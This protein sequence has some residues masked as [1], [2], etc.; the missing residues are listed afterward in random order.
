MAS[1]SNEEN[2]SSKSD[3]MTALRDKVGTAVSIRTQRRKWSGRTDTWDRHNDAGMV[4]VAAK[5]IE[6]CEIRP[7]MD[8]VDLG[9]GTGRLTLQL[10][11]R[12]VNIIGVDVSAAMIER[13][14]A[15]AQ[16]QEA[17][18]GTVTGLAAPIERLSLGAGSVDLVITNYALHHLLDADKGKVVKAAYGWLRPGGQLVVADMMLGRGTTS[19]DREIIADKVRIMAQKGLPGYWRILKNAG[20]YLFRVHERPITPEAWARLLEDAGFADVRIETVVAEAA[21]VKGVKP[22]G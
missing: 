13:M 3:L 17:G 20:R 21:V 12:G 18:M 22:N 1:P 11:E 15:Q 19:R 5:A 7:G 4:K 2:V 9:C 10:A 16:A 6:V 8:G 14:E